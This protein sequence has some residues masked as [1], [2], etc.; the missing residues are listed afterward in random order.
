MDLTKVTN[1][2]MV[3]LQME[4]GEQRRKGQSGGGGGQV[5]LSQNCL[6]TPPPQTSPGCSPPPHP[7][8]SSLIRISL[9]TPRIY[10]V[11][12]FHFP[13]MMSPLQSTRACPPEPRM[14]VILRGRQMNQ[15]VDTHPFLFPP[16]YIC[17]LLNGGLHDP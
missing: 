13:D 1:C 11:K 3:S 9:T 2:P 15:G 7:A 17:L 5:P 8:A 12:C 10:N 14:E 4:A 6:W 16:Y